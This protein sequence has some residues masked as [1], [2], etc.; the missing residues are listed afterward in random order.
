MMNTTAAALLKPSSM[1]EKEETKKEAAVTMMI[2]D[3]ENEPTV[4]MAVDNFYDSFDSIKK[5]NAEQTQNLE[6]DENT[7]VEWN[8][9]R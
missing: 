6:E 4:N 5:D 9:V 2:A 7:P 3:K 8:K 1:F